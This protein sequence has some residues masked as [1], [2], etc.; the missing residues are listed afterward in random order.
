[1]L[2]YLVGPKDESASIK[3]EVRVK[4]A[5]LLSKA[6][7][8]KLENKYSSKAAEYTAIEIERELYELFRARPTADEYKARFRCLYSNLGGAGNHDLRRAVL[9]GEVGVPELCRMSSEEMMSTTQREEKAR[10]E[11]WLLRE[12]TLTG[13]KAMTSE[14]RCNRCGHRETSYY[15]MQTRSGDEPMTLFVEC[16]NCGNRWK[17][18]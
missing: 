2:T 9:D 11:A 12:R 18:S 14:F 16:C 1:M 10:L 5:E 13:P 17:M 3:R 8:D 6:I 4:I 15:Q 7:Q